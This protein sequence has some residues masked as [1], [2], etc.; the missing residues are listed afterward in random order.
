[1][2]ATVTYFP[3][4]VPSTKVGG[5]TS[6]VKVTVRMALSPP[7]KPAAVTQLLARNCAVKTPDSVGVTR[8]TPVVVF[9]FPLNQEAGTA[10]APRM[11]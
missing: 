3:A 4:S 11:E 2:P 7:P 5:V 9:S 10:L 8:K 1:M 6:I